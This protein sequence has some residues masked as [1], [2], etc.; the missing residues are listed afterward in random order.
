MSIGSLGFAG[1][2]AATPLAQAKG[3]DTDREAQETTAQ[4]TQ[5][6]T[7]LQAE[8]AAGIG[9]T[10][11]DEHET[12]ERDADGRRPWE[13]PAKKKNAAK[14]AETALP[15]LPPVPSRDATGQCGNTLDLT[16]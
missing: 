9:Q 8:Q 14:A 16:G 1:I 15:S 2:G 11:G 4:Q 7:D 5:Q 6:Q 10:D 13:L 3:T 12:E